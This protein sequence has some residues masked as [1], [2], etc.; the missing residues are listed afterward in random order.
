MNSY[1]LV[2]AFHVIFI[3][4]WM[5]MLVYLP[6]L[7]VYHI[8][9][10][11]DYQAVI[12]LQEANLYKIGTVAMVFS[13]KFGLILLYLNPYLLKS[14]GWLHVKLALVVCMVI[15][16]FMCKKFINQFA[17]EGISKNIQFFKIFRVIPEIT[18]SLI[19]LLT[20]NKPF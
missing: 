18:T 12:A 13:I 1:N 19:I 15:Y 7:F 20:I 17:K 16:H 5:I 8:N 10:Q 9:A 6:K 4:T 3:A 14:G 11:Q 2:L